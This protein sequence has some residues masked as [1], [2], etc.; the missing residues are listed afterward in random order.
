MPEGT[1]AT[2]L[3]LLRD[4]RRQAQELAATLGIDTSAV[5]RH[6]ETLR[7]QGLVDSVEAV[8]GPGRPKMM[9]GLTAA[10][11][12]AFPRDYALLL[13]LVTAKLGETEGRAALERVMGA[14][15]EDLAKGVAAK[16]DPE[17]RV[18]ALVAFY[19]RLG[20]E[21]SVERTRDGFAITQRNCIF[22][23]AATADPPLLCECLDEGIMRAALPSADVRF[24][25]SLATGAPRCRHLLRLPRLS[26]SP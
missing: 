1:A 7:A 22:L 10:G 21:A 26:G 23:R 20:F 11:R 17:G 15:A 14:I 9:Y 12:E 18:K 16:P 2:L 6:L 8:A 19:N 13:S 3:A 25:G 24:E 4:G 5:R